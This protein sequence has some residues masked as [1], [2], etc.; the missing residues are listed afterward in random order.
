[1]VLPVIPIT[2][3]LI[4]ESCVM[5]N[6]LLCAD[7]CQN[8]N[9]SRFNVSGDASCSNNNNSFQCLSSQQK[10]DFF[11]DCQVNITS[12]NC[13][14]E[15]NIANF[16]TSGGEYSRYVACNSVCYTGFQT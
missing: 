7:Y 15:D 12:L 2:S 10:L 5:G 4:E 8:K 6:G 14:I 13:S 1:M 16:C 11:C 9:P 3:A